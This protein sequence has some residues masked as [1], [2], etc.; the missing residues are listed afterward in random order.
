MIRLIEICLMVLI[1]AI[2]MIS[3]PFNIL[4]SIHS[5]CNGIIKFYFKFLQNLKL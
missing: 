1:S 3:Q 4:T 2:P 5:K